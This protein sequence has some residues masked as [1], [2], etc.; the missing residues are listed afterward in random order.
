MYKK[1]KK[2]KQKEEKMK[3]RQQEWEQQ[4]EKGKKD[5]ASVEQE[6]THRSRHHNFTTPTNKE[7]DRKTDKQTAT[8]PPKIHTH[9]GDRQTGRA[10][11]QADHYKFTLQKTLKN[12]FGPCKKETHKKERQTGRMTQIRCFS[13]EDKTGVERNANVYR[14]GYSICWECQWCWCTLRP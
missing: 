11:R 2:K 6:T 12:G 5:F 1:N 7:T 4:E 10:G 3:R 9:T 8:K 13:S 14:G